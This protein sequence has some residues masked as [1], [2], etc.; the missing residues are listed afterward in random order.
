MK[1]DLNENYR[2]ICS[3]KNQSGVS[4]YNDLPTI[5]CPG[6]DYIEFVLRADVFPIKVLVSVQEILK[7]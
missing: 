3:K 4:W 7:R 6:F 2:V 1:F 5:I